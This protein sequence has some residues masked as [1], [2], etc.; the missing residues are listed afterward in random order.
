MPIRSPL[1]ARL[2]DQ[3]RAALGPYLERYATDPPVYTLSPDDCGGFLWVRHTSKDELGMGRLCAGYAPD[4]TV[5]CDA[6]TALEPAFLERAKVWCDEYARSD[7]R[8]RNAYPRAFW[9]AGRTLAAELAA[10]LGGAG[11]VFMFIKRLAGPDIHRQCS[12]FSSNGKHHTRHVTEV[13]RTTYF[14]ECLNTLVPKPI[15]AST[16]EDFDRRALSLM[17]PPMH[18]DW[19]AVQW[20]LAS[21]CSHL[22]GPLPKNWIRP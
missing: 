4:G 2:P 8:G 15:Q 19:M 5:F 16:G 22:T 1:D 10:H 18:D 3:V 9:D 13:H 20:L 11:R 7:A 21:S 14:I 6:P 12:W 17:Y